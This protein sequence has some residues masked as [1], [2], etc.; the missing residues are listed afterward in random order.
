MVQ[1]NAIPLNHR[2][3]S[4]ISTVAKLF[5]DIINNRIVYYMEANDLFAEEQNG[6]RKMRSCLHHLFV[7][8][9]II[10]NRKKDNLPTFACYID[11]TRAFDGINRT[12]L[13]HKRMHYK[14]NGKLL[15]IIKTI[16]EHVQSAVRIGHELTDWFSVKSGVRQ[17]DIKPRSDTFCHLH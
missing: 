3:I 8:T 9:T 1:I 10:R 16:Y 7:L 11:F 4:L 17:G 15:L 6:F 14:V 13:W 12:L 5:S 2:A